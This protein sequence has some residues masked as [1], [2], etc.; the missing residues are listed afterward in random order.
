MRTIILGGTGLLGQHAAVAA[1]A[2]GDSVTLVA[3]RL[4]DLL[5]GLKRPDGTLAEGVRFVAGDVVAATAADLAALVSGHDALIYA[6]GPDDREPSPRPAAAYFQR[7]LVEQTE[8]VIAAAR[9]AGVRRAVLC[10][11]YFATWDR[12]HPE[13]GF[14]SRHCYVRARIDQAARAVVAGGGGDAVA[15]CVVEIP[16]VFGAVPGQVPMWKEWLFDRLLAMPVVCYPKGGTAVV[17]ARQVGQALA[18]ASAV[19]VHDARYPLADE[20]LSWT[21]LLAL[22]LPLLGK[23]SRVITVPRFLAETTARRLGRELARDGLESGIDP[24]HLMR[25]VM[26]QQ[27][28][29]EGSASVAALGY[30]R[31]GVPAAIA[32]AVA[33]SYPER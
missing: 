12:L 8:R 13:L 16:Y 23:S 25:D 20:N 2:R 6:L 5:P 24:N 33:A 30:Q 1:L 9:V 11:S 7:L 15:V 27:M 31:G 26:Y 29:I 14:A 18:A 22:I 4:G 28:F 3:R 17:T 10:G 19:G 21:G 32:E